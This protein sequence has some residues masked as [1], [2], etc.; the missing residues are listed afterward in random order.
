L[1]PLLRHHLLNPKRTLR[2]QLL[3]PVKKPSARN[4]RNALPFFASLRKKRKKHVALRKF[5]RHADSS[6][7]LLNLLRLLLPRH[8]LLRLFTLYQS[9][10]LSTRK[11]RLL[12]LLRRRRR[13]LPPHLLRE[14][15]QISPVLILSVE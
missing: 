13:H 2:T 7:W 5:I 10:N 8:H 11:R 4:G 1:C 6:S 12:L 3:K 14:C 9:L 15:Q